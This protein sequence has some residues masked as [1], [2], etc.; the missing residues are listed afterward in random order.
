MAESFFA[1]LECELLARQSFPTQMAARTALFAYLEV[2][3]NRQ[4]R[5]SALGYLAP[6]AYESRMNGGGLLT[7]RLLPNAQQSIEA[8]QLQPITIHV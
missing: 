6:V 3:Y 1:T 4:R 8:G 5:H 2:F 7:Q